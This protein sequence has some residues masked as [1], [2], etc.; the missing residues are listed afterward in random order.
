[1]KNKWETPPQNILNN[2][3]EPEQ[4]EVVAL[5]V[6]LE[7]VSEVMD[8]PELVKAVGI[9]VLVWLCQND[10]LIYFFQCFVG[11]ELSLSMVQ[12]VF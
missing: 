4:G 3:L 6:H 12:G 8:N 1:M 9:C 11:G 7:N 5:V 10:I 2:L